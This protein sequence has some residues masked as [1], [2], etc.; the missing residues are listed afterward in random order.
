MSE[1][2]LNRIDADQ[3]RLE[4]LHQNL[5]KLLTLPFDWNSYGAPQISPERVQVAKHI[6]NILFGIVQGGPIYIVPTT[7]GG[8]QLEFFYNQYEIELEINDASD[9]TLFHR[10]LSTGRSQT[11]DISLGEVT[12]T[13]VEYV[14]IE[15]DERQSMGGDPTRL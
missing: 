5:D 4:G 2:K 13:E 15:N 11:F 7:F 8:V 1:N 3:K 14:E 10:D 12:Q 6:L 9:I